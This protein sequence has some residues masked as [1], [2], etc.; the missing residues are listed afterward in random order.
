M[1]ACLWLGE[2]VVRVATFMGLD[3]NDE[4]LIQL[5]L[6]RA[7]F[8]FMSSEMHWSSS[9]VD[10]PC[11]ACMCSL[12]RDARARVHA[13]L[14]GASRCPAFTG[15][16]QA[17]HFDDHYER[18]KILPKMGLSPDTPLRVSKVRRDGARGA[19]DDLSDDL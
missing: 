5:V 10:E 14:T 11:L 8:D 7:S 4:P 12:R 18:S 16:K 17:H 15:E 13:F 3:P 2:Q 19:S 1:H 6:E 9:H